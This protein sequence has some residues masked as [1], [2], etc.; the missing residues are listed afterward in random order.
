M[1]DTTPSLGIFWALTDRHART[2]LLTLPCALADAEPYGDCLTSAAG[3]HERGRRGA[4]A[5]PS[6]R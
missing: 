1:P 3:H 5:S 2:H 4:V 6:H